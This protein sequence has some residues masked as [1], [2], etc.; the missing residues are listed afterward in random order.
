MC[1]WR[2]FL[3]VAMTPSILRADLYNTLDKVLQGGEPVEIQRKGKTLK[4][5]LDQAGRLDL[6]EPHPN[7]ITGNADDIVGIS[8]EDEWKPVI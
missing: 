2:T 3:V 8:W 7:V 1:A 6:L 4:I 5:V